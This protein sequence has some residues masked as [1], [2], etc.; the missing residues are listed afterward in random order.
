MQLEIL[1]HSSRSINSIYIYKNFLEDKEKLNLYKNKITNHTYSDLMNRE[2][3]VKAN[4]TK[5]DDLLK[6]NDFY[7]LHQSFL[8][9]VSNTIKLRS[10]SELI[11]FKIFNSWGMSHYKGDHTIAHVHH[12]L[13]AGV[14]Y[15]DVPCE[16][17]IRFEEYNC[18][19]LLENNL[20]IFFPGYTV[21]E[22]ST[23]TSDVPR[24]SM[25]FNIDV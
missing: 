17:F 14:F 8:K 19:Y 7:S 1:Q 3:N 12:C 22:V 9:T 24:I 25:A 5:Y 10:P 23:H 13:F 11:P 2:T 21:H 18:N 20:F 16:T 4:M 15:I 6:D